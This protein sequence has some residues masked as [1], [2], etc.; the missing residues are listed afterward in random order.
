MVKAV[1]VAQ[2]LQ[3]VQAVQAVHSP[4]ANVL[5]CLLLRA[6]LAWHAAADQ[7]KAP[8]LLDKLRWA[9][10][11]AQGARLPLQLLLQPRAVGMLGLPAATPQK[12][13]DARRRV[14]LLHELPQP[15]LL[16]ARRPRRLRHVL[17]QRPWPRSAHS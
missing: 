3:E 4:L 10:G 16:L 5:P 2:A 1:Q 6:L 7:D 12:E 13:K 11:V 15:Q 8:R 17:L 14:P 9:G